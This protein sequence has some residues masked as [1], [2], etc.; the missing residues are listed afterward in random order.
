MIS[1]IANQNFRMIKE[2]ARTDNQGRLTLGNEGKE[3]NYRVMMNDAGQILLDQYWK[4]RRRNC[5]CGATQ[6]RWLP[7][8]EALNKL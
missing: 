1:M 5:G 3:K 7:C 2:T 4:Y 8:K 6:K